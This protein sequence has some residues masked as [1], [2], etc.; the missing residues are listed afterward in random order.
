MLKLGHYFSHV[1]LDAS[2]QMFAERAR[3]VKPILTNLA[4]TGDN[5]AE[6]IVPDHRETLAVSNRGHR[7][8]QSE[9]LEKIVA[10][11][12]PLEPL[13][14]AHRR[15]TFFR[16]SATDFVAKLTLNMA[17]R[18]FITISKFMTT[19]KLQQTNYTNCGQGI[20]TEIS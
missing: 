19:T 1:S 11:N 13:E 17:H 16:Q 20:L 15:F 4:G 12:M 2:E 3:S 10:N 7:N 9:N 6:N 14:P 8:F 5:H 18:E